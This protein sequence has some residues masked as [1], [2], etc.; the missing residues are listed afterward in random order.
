MAF[1][2]NFIKVPYLRIV[3]RYLEYFQ[4]STDITAAVIPATSSYSF[5]DCEVIIPKVT[6]CANFMMGTIL[7]LD[8][9]Y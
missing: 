2:E 6:G 8:L 4:D 5:V 1:I 7:L 3:M 9:Y